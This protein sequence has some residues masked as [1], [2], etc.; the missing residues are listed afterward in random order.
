MTLLQWG[1]LGSFAFYLIWTGV[2]RVD[3]FE[4]DLRM[5]RADLMQVSRVV[6]LHVVLCSGLTLMAAVFMS[7]VAALEGD[8]ERPMRM[9][10]PTAAQYDGATVPG[11]NS[12]EAER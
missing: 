5:Y 10:D 7:L 1:V 8:R 12:E 11:L 2:L 6:I 3:L 4:H 9:I